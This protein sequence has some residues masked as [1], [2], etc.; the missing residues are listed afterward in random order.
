MD[1]LSAPPVDHADGRR[2]R[3]GVPRKAPSIA[4]QVQEKRARLGVLIR[5]V[6]L[7][8]QAQCIQAVAEILPAVILS[9]DNPD[10]DNITPYC[11]G[12]IDQAGGCPCVIYLDPSAT[13]KLPHPGF[14][15]EV[16]GLGSNYM[17]PT[18]YGPNAPRPRLLRVERRFK[19]DWNNHGSNALRLRSLYSS[20]VNSGH[21]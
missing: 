11:A 16:Q 9:W 3:L 8:V 15:S 6:F 12:D 17:I 2:G 5:L 4:C 13:L 18:G 7:L 20:A 14:Q 19:V 10:T 21:E 1:S